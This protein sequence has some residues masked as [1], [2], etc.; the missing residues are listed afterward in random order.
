MMLPTIS[1]SLVSKCNDLISLL[2]DCVAL[3]DGFDPFLKAFA[4]TFDCASCTLAICSNDTKTIV[5]GWFSE[6]TPEDT[7]WYI[8]HLTHVDPLWQLVTDKSVPEFVS[9]VL[10]NIHS[11]NPAIVEWCERQGFHDGAAA[12]VYKDASISFIMTISRNIHFPTFT[13]SELNVYDYFIPHLRRAISLR[14]MMQKTANYSLPFIEILQHLQQPIIL[15]NRSF[16]LEFINQSAEKLISEEP[17]LSL[18]DKVFQL[19]DLEQ[20][21]SLLGSFYRFT[22]DNTLHSQE[23]VIFPILQAQS[24]SHMTLVLIPIVNQLPFAADNEGSSGNVLVLINHWHSLHSI[25]PEQ[26][27]DFFD[28]SKTEAKVCEL[29][30]QGKSPENI[31]ETLNR[32]I[33]TVRSHLKSIYQK[34]GTSRQ[35][36]LV[37]HVL[38]ALLELPQA[39]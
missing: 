32:S 26:I 17:F 38:T 1:E 10:N 16:Q 30:C 6:M 31:A 19:N 34:T 21:A 25:Q 11:D 9:A 8:K 33:P 35:N 22:H 18:N 37:A 27:A 5:G 15:L 29:L 13:Q 7:Q 24:H 36:E 20:Q 12:P 23:K 4:N 14:Q 28:L 3:P 2:Y 39:L